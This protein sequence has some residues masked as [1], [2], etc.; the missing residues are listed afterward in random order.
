MSGRLPALIDPIRLADEGARL[1]GEL[2]G[3][4]LARLREW[5]R[6]GSP[7]APVA[8]QLEFERSP[9]GV[10]LMHGRIRT[11]IDTV[12]QRCLG[13]L[14]VALEARPF[15]V[16]LLPG[17]APAGI[18]D[19]AEALVVEG[20]VSLNELVEDELLLVFPMIPAHAAGA[21]QAPGGAADENAKPHPFAALRGWKGS[22]E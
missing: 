11:E 2:P 1:A 14:A 15:S 16:L 10:R 12:C 21:C 5:R 22:K 19:E 18:P 7:P 8:V 3:G 20:P 6:P 13:P 4:E 17:E 9:H